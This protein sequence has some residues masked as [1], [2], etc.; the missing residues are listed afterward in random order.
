M[1]EPKSFEELERLA[2][3]GPSLYDLKD[4]LRDYVYGLSNKAYAKGDADRDAICDLSALELR[5]TYIREC[6]LKSIG[7]LPAPSVSLDARITGTLA[8]DGYRIEKIIYSPRENVHVTSNM[9]IPDGVKPDGKNAAVIMVCGHWDIGKKGLPI[10][11]ACQLLVR[12]GL[13]VFAQ[14]PVGQGERWSYINTEQTVNCNTEEHDYAGFQCLPLGHSIARYFVHDTMRALDYLE[15]RP[16]V[17]AKKIGIT[18]ASG[19][20][21]QSCMMMMAER[22]IAA[23]APSCFVMNRKHYMKTGQA[24]DREQIWPGLTEWGIDHEDFVLAMAP[25]PVMLLA[26]AH[27]FFPVE[28]TFR[29]YRRCARFWEMHGRRD[30]LEMATDEIHHQYT[31]S[32]VR[33][34]ASFFAKHLM[35]KDIDQDNYADDSLIAP[36]PIEGSE[37]HCTRT[38]QART[39]FSGTYAVY[40]EN[41]RELRASLNK[42]AGI[43]VCERKANALRFLREKVY[44]NR[45]PEESRYLKRWLINPPDWFAMEGGL[46]ANGLLWISQEG[47][48]NTGMLFTRESDINKLLLV[49]I[50]LWEGGTRNL[51]E[52]ERFIKETCQN[53]R[54]AFVVD[55]TGTG[56]SLQR[57]LSAKEDPHAF[58]GCIFKLNDDMLWLNDSIAALRTYDLLRL[59]DIAANHEMFDA[60]GGVEIYTHGR[61][62]VY[63]DVARFVDEQ[64]RIKKV[65]SDEPLKSYG[66]FIN[67]RFYERSDIASVILPGLL[68]YADLDELREWSAGIIC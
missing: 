36:L 7:G 28:S 21:T 9:Y 58:Y 54:F 41:M 47:V 40:E 60:T 55:T 57:Q 68:E 15:T 22:R 14:D 37:L 35:G 24:Q 16:E 6:F 20:G 34:S 18:G 3:S 46:A 12:A 51:A 50:A 66:D 13:I 11:A 25:R 63:A 23:A 39:S 27:D 8:F 32:N 4:E 38:G 44:K 42:R 64:N 29:T 19:G 59:V 45:K 61:Y 2:K 62:S 67:G 5:Q 53:G 10:Q 1:S 17:D 52:H 48:V 49:T 26:A 56:M 30:C 33:K 43:P 65:V 31:R